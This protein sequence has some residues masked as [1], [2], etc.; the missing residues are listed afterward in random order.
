MNEVLDNYAMVGTLKKETTPNVNMPKADHWLLE[1][2]PFFR[3]H[4][5]LEHDAT[6]CDGNLASCLGIKPEYASIH[7]GVPA[8][9]DD[10]ISF[11][12]LPSNLD[13]TYPVR[14]TRFAV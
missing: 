4:T 10:A 11:Y 14:Y 3:R 2:N 12:W 13:R 1:T 8:V 5:L 6:R 9:L 7:D